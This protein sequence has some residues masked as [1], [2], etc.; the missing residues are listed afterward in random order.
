MERDR[1]DHQSL[2]LRETQVASPPPPL[3]AFF[4]RVAISL[5]R[6]LL[7]RRAFSAVRCRLSEFCLASTTKAETA[8]LRCG[9]AARNTG[10]KARRRRAEI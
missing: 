10:R 1:L 4:M 2:E 9:A 5:L 3:L 8:T 7:C 6:L